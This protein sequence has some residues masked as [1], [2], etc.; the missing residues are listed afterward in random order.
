MSVNETA[1]LGGQLLTV[2]GHRLRLSMAESNT[3]L[4]EQITH[5]SPA[6]STW[7]SG[8]VSNV[9]LFTKVSQCCKWV[10]HFG[11]LVPLKLRTNL[12]I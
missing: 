7:I 5:M 11:P 1:V 10:I 2:A 9:H 4:K 12:T 3:Q 8:L 6:L